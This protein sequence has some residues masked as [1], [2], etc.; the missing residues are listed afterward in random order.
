MEFQALSSRWHRIWVTPGCV[1]AAWQ[2]ILPLRIDTPGPSY[3]VL[4]G[5][6]FSDLT[7]C[8]VTLCLLPRGWWLLTP[9]GCGV[10]EM[11]LVCIEVYCQHKM[12]TRFQRL[13]KKKKI[14]QSISF[15][16]GKEPF[17]L[18]R[19]CSL[20]SFLG[21]KILQWVSSEQVAWNYFENL[22][23]T[24]LLLLVTCS[25]APQ[26]FSKISFLLDRSQKAECRLGE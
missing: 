21:R 11:W 10:L 1:S 13:N 26:N 22:I 8:D 4:Y 2:I 7:P 5:D 15:A 17:D 19:S 23:I 9:W 12:H 25:E 20:P 3:P 16:F 24:F 14:L 18:E 6:C